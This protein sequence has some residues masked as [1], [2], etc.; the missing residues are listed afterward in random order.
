MAYTGQ[1]IFALMNGNCN[2]TTRMDS[3]QVAAASL[4][5]THHEIVSELSEI[6]AVMSGAWEGGAAAQANAGMNPFIDTS[7]VAA[8]HL[9]SAGS[10]LHAQNSV[11]HDVRGKLQPVGGDR[12]DDTGLFDTLSIGASD[13][14][15]DAAKWDAAN[16]N[17]IEQYGVYSN[18]STANGSGM[19]AQHYPP[20]T[21]ELGTA[22]LTQPT[23]PSAV[24]AAGG[25]VS[26]VHGPGSGVVSGPG[27][28]SPPPAGAGPG[29]QYPGVNG[30]AT[31]RP[32]ATGPTTPAA[33]AP[34]VQDVTRPAAYLPGAGT[35]SGPDGSGVG[36]PAHSAGGSGAGLVP[37]G[38]GPAGPGGQSSN[39]PA[40]RAGTNVAPGTGTGTGSGL[41]G[42]RVA[43]GGIG[44]GPGSGVGGPGPGAGLTPGKGV[45]VGVPGT[46][47][48][49][50]AGAAG[51]GAAGPRGGAGMGGMAPA[52]GAG[53]GKGGEDEEHQ[54]KITI[55]GDD[56]DELFGGTPGRTTPPVIG[57]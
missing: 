26:T 25:Q 40:G 35:G 8:G 29:L 48:A 55:P 52:G 33:A 9:D 57:A 39:G 49:G 20:I 4:T 51:S 30:P 45:G 34:P 22:G 54:A 24:D 32:A 3:A 7:N 2:T 37:G 13:A 47:G 10:N 14:E 17:N 23:A 12:P 28:G 1:Q 56:P 53:R 16:K 38:F 36:R 27:G 31:P 5:G 43:G 11:F 15:K 42:G 41:A 18:G 6:Q 21:P 19:V 44:S 50:G 46:T